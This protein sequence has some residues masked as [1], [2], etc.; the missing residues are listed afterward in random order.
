ML[1]RKL[2]RARDCRDFCRESGGF[3]ASQ[4]FPVTYEEHVDLDEKKHLRKLGERVA[5]VIMSPLL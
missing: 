4:R 1:E 3:S 2:P 5:E